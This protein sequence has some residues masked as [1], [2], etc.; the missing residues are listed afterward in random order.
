MARTPSPAHSPMSTST[1]TTTTSTTAATTAA[2]QGT[3]T[4]TGSSN[5][6]INSAATN[7][8][9]L[10]V[11]DF[12]FPSHLISIQDRKDEALTD[13][14]G[15]K[16]S[17]PEFM[18][19]GLALV[20]V[21]LGLRLCTSVVGPVL[22]GIVDLYPQRTANFASNG[23]LLGQNELQSSTVEHEVLFPPQIWPDEPQLQHCI[24][25]NA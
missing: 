8:V 1:T 6:S 20:R 2:L 7:N 14:F 11:D 4:T 12:N 17:F 23:T 16:Q 5:F 3:T 18:V 25:L 13:W 19:E 15:D 21:I 24:S 9:A 22:D 10:S